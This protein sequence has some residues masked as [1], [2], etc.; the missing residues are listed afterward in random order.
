MAP[1]IM[2]SAL[3]EPFREEDLDWRIQSAGYK[4]SGEP[5]ARVLVYVTNRAIQQR[6][7]DA[8]GPA[9]W[10]NEYSFTAGSGVLCG[11]SILCDHVWITKWDGIAL[12]LEPRSADVD[13]IKSALSGAMKR[14]GVQWGIGRYLYGVGE[15]WAE[16][17]DRGAQRSRIRSQ[18]GRREEWHRWSPPALPSWAL[19]GRTG[20]SLLNPPEWFDELTGF[21]SRP[22]GSLGKE[23][24]ITTWREMSQGSASGGRR[25]LL[26][27]WAEL[28]S[29]EY[30]EPADAELRGQ[31]ERAEQRAR[32]VLSMLAASR[33]GLVR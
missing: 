26:E 1:D 28:S 25:R 6:L 14:A 19:P 31:M 29:S 11:L 27:A 23:T 33:E 18:D 13:P 10:R 7:D 12:E 15:C 8:C 17:H 32:V 30:Y 2:F 24:N 22:A 20:G 5:W 3:G 16:F 21:G 4:A 9:C